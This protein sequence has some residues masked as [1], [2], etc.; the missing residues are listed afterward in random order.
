MAGIYIWHFPDGTGYIGQTIREIEDRIEEEAKGAFS[1]KSSEYTRN[2]GV[3]IRKHGL[4]GVTFSIYEEDQNYGVDP[5][6]LNLFQNTLLNSNNEPISAI[7]AAE[8]LHIL[9]SVDQNDG[10]CKLNTQ[11]GG[12]RGIYNI[13]QSNGVILKSMLDKNSSPL[14]AYQLLSMSDVRQENITKYIEIFE[15]VVFTDRWDSFLSFAKNIKPD[16]QITNNLKLD[17]PTFVKDNVI[18]TLAVWT[19]VPNGTKSIQE[20]LSLWIK[21]KMEVLFQFLPQYLNN[22][23]HQNNKQFNSDA[24]RDFKWAGQNLYKAITDADSELSKSIR[25]QLHIEIGRYLTA[26]KYIYNN[27]TKHGSIFEQMIKNIE[28]IKKI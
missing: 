5:K 20:S 8:I 6:L 24:Y 4:K 1:K 28:K 10:L 2:L 13:R 27:K 15:D 18:K 7:D 12:Q 23:Y 22:Y 25:K 19:T 3:Y 11:M 26:G 17:W 21:E 9:K 14:E 16:L